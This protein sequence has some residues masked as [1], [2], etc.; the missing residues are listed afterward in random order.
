MFGGLQILGA[1]P[2]HL[3]GQAR[4]GEGQHL[5]GDL[6]LGPGPDD[7]DEPVPQRRHR[8]IAVQVV[9]DDGV[10]VHSDRPQHHR[11]HE[12]GAVLTGEAVRQHRPTCCQ[13]RHHSLHR[14]AGPGE[15]G[16]AL[17]LLEHVAGGDVAGGLLV[18]FLGHHLAERVL[19]RSRA[20]RCLVAGKVRERQQV[21]AHPVGH[22]PRAAAR[23][24]ARG[25]QI[26]HVGHSESQQLFAAAILEATQFAGPEQPAGA[27]HAGGLGDIA[28]IPRPGQSRLGGHPAT[29]GHR[30][31]G[32]TDQT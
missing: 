25:P 9:G 26:G 11:H 15:G 31:C 1:H 7:L 22:Q 19:V 13:Q 14:P 12:A 21:D 17:V 20:V 28:K 4:F 30:G 18:G 23:D 24:F 8:V 5:R 16:E 3:V 10:T 2:E 29:I 32:V 6:G 27:Q